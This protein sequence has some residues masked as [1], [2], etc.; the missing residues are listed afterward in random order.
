ML[1]IKKGCSV[2]CW[3][4]RCKCDTNHKILH[5]EKESDSTD[6][7]WWEEAYAIA[8]CQGC[9][10]ICFYRETVDDSDEV[11]DDYEFGNFHYEPHHYTYPY[12]Q[13]ASE[14]IDTWQLP[15]DISGI[16]KETI[17][18][19]NN[20]N[21]RLAAIGF[22]SI[23]ESICD[24]CKIKSGN[25]A[26]RINSLTTQ[27]LI[28]KADRDRLHSIRFIG[29]DAVHAG[30][31][32]SKNELLVVA[33][34]VNGILNNRYLIERQ[35]RELEERPVRTY[36]EFVA[37]LDKHLLTRAFGDEDTL[38]NLMNAPREVIADDL[39]EYETQLK[40]DITAGKYDKLQPTTLTPKGVQK[41][42]VVKIK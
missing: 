28:T 35:Y 18:S 40:A 25:L 30:K 36:A 37:L 9:D 26:T 41:Y 11:C 7:Y 27:K 16:Y 31:L 33:A 14:P 32:F 1:T 23:I 34:I 38:M 6:D 13:L 22:R 21:L 29:N 4:P 10:D 3:C 24:D 15:G 8:Q 5:V 39:A 20:D 12:S 17:S 42:K 2:K 19:L